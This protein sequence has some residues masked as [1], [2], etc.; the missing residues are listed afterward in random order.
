MRTRRAKVHETGDG[1]DPE[2]LGVDK[3]ATVE[4]GEMV[5]LDTWMGERN[6]KRRAD[7]KAIG[8]QIVQGERNI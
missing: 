8:Q 6:I 4:L 3:I 1:D 5:V 7:Q 2:V